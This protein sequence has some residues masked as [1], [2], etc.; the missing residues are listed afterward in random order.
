MCAKFYQ[1]SWKGPRLTCWLFVNLDGHEAALCVWQEPHPRALP[2]A[3]VKM[4]LRLLGLG[5]FPLSVIPYPSPSS[6][7]KEGHATK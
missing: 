6:P 1:L 3:E 4:V 5:A 2:R 7:L